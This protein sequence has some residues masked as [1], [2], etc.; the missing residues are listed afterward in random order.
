MAPTLAQSIHTA[1]ETYNMAPTPIQSVYN[2]METYVS[3]RLITIIMPSA[4][5][6]TVSTPLYSTTKPT[7]PAHT[8]WYGNS[9]HGLIIGYI[10]TVMLIVILLLATAHLIFLVCAPVYMACQKI[11]WLWRGG[12]ATPQCAECQT[13]QFAEAGTETTVVWQPPATAQKPRSMNTTEDRDGLEDGHTSERSDSG[14]NGWDMD[15]GEFDIE[16]ADSEGKVGEHTE[17]LE[18]RQK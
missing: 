18:K 8:P 14:R 6:H 5:A 16:R 7:D 2:A 12:S 11:L 3:S 1:N 15:C 9:T 4:T 17:L 10:L 13:R